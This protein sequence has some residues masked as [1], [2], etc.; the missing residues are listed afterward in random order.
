MLD[1]ARALF[2][3]RGYAGTSVEAVAAAAGVATP[4]IYFT[5]GSKRVL[6]KEV[7]DVS[8][9]GDDSAVPTMERPWF[10]EAL[11]EPDPAAQLRLQVRAARR[12]LERAA[13]V[14]EVVRAAAPA[15][16]EVAAL[17][18]VNQEQRLT[19]QR[20]LAAALAGKTRLR[21]DV[22]TAADILFAVLGPE[23]F[24][25][26]TTTRGWSSA[27]WEDWAVDSLAVQLLTSREERD[28]A[29]GR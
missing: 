10:A 25:V 5:F 23:L 7:L 27:R 8:V 2:V 9:A 20:R 13:A 6:L 14:L 29:P 11:A 24:G 16:D 28:D 15:D 17:W 3:E 18:R 12:I 19:V 22:D 4:T 21:H 1:A 26:L